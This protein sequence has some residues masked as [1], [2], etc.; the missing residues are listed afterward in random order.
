MAVQEGPKAIR[1]DLIRDGILL[2][3]IEEHEKRCSYR[4]LEVR[5]R[6]IETEGEKAVERILDML[7]FDHQLRP[8]ACERI[9]IPRDE[10][11][12]IFGRPLSQTV[13]MYGLQVKREAD[14]SLCLTT[15]DGP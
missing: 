6:G 15:L 1:K 8:F 7:K 13:T 12:L 9:G 11:D 4:E 10:T 2:G 14:G 5:V 3:L